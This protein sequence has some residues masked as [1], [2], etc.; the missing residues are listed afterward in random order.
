MKVVGRT[1][2]R[3]SYGYIEY[4]SRT[5]HFV[6]ITGFQPQQDIFVAIS[7]YISLSFYPGAMRV[8]AEDIETAAY[9]GMLVHCLLRQV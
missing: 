4:F 8:L 7:R 6:G 9:P 5:V 1:R 2:S 3:I